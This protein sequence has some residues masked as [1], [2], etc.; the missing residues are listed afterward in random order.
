MGCERPRQYQA[1]AEWEAIVDALP[2]VEPLVYCNHVT[3]PTASSYQRKYHQVVPNPKR[4][5]ITLGH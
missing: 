1:P 3:E 5:V 2:L 4:L